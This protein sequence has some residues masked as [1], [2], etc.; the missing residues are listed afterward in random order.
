MN[1]HMYVY[2]CKHCDEFTHRSIYIYILP[3]QSVEVEICSLFVRP[4]PY[5]ESKEIEYDS[6]FVNFLTC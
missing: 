2:I 3:V 1:A 6:S 5:L 4:L